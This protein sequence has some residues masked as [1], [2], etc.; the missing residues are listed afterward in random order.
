MAA[1]SW[2]IWL[3]DA[4]GSSTGTGA[5]LLDPGAS[6]VIDTPA[7]DTATSAMQSEWFDAPW[8]KAA[9]VVWTWTARA[10]ANQAGGCHVSTVVCGAVGVGAAA[11]EPVPAAR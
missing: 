11:A 9:P 6:L 10:A 3:I 5:V 1:G 8:L 7:G 2:V 4:H